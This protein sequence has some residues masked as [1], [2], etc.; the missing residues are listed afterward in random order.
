MLTVFKT[1]AN[2]FRLLSSSLTVGA[3][4]VTKVHHY[5]PSF[6][7]KTLINLVCVSALWELHLCIQMP[8]KYALKI[9]GPNSAFGYTTMKISLSSLSLFVYIMKHCLQRI[10]KTISTL[11][12]R[13]F[14]YKA[15]PNQL[16]IH[17]SG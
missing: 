17:M 15:L 2:V 16:L 3:L 6:T 9:I 11:S 13:R 5:K 14:Y 4:T 10:L 8:T 1:S 12:S 7:T